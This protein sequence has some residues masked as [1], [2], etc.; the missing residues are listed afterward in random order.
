MSTKN[1]ARLSQATARGLRL[2]QT[3]GVL[4]RSLLASSQ[5]AKLFSPQTFIPTRA[6]VPVP[7]T[8]GQRT[9]KL[10]IEKAYTVAPITDSQY[11][12]VSDEYMEFVCTKFEELQDE[13]EDIDVEYS[14]SCI[15]FPQV[16]RAEVLTLTL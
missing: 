10:E 13:R 11:H 14:A 16:F 12:D 3:S 2:S 5:F 9:P 6:Y 7:P 15:H 8:G 4:T 1:L